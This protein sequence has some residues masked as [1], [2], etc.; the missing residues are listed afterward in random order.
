MMWKKLCLLGLAATLLLLPSVGQAQQQPIRW[1]VTLD[2][3]QRVAGQTN[4]LVLIEF[5]ATWCDYCKRMDTEVFSQPSVM[6][7]VSA[8]YVA[9][10]INADHFPATAKQ[11]GVTALPTTVIITPQ[12]QLLDSMKG[13]VEVAEYVARLSRAAADVKQRGAVY[14]Q[15][16]SSPNSPALTQPL[17]GQPA[18]T[19][20]APTQPAAAQPAPTV[21]GLSD[22]RYAD[23][24]RR[25]QTAQA[26][27]TGQP[28]NT[29]S[30]PMGQAASAPTGYVGAPTAPS[31]GQPAPGFGQSP[32]NYPQVAS[33]A[34]ASY[35]PASSSAPTTYPQGASAAPTTYPQGAS[36]APTT[37]PQQAS[38]APMTGSFASPTG[39]SQPYPPSQP[40]MTSPQAAGQPPMSA[41]IDATR[42]MQSPQSPVGQ[43]MS[44]SSAG[45]IAP[46]P[47]GNPPWGLEGFC[48][49]TLVEKQQWVPGDRRYGMAHRGRTYLFT[50]P[51]ELRRFAAD[52]DRYA[53]V[54]S[55]NDIVLATDQGQTVSGMREHG[56]FFGNRIYLFSNEATLDKFQKN[57][58]QY[59]NQ[60][61]E[62]LRSGAYPG[63]QLR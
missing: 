62:A 6:S 47:S 34:P 53:P 49:V 7:E 16:P 46:P 12:G 37:Y 13:K 17:A 41:G 39:R 4:R 24:F 35:P 15:V 29:T 48:P 2:N 26:A 30:A 60:A 40:S 21:T 56:V 10:K 33:T 32:T 61:L 9:V 59:A 31:V 11:Y 23:F 5:W 58:N 45:V 44:P 42:N 22:D 50:G 18:T 3:A 54:A 8:D 27:P 38:T 20:P 63:R 25:N 55:G 43:P 36:A 52:P 51:E 57:P 14:A 19:Q 1:E 28:T